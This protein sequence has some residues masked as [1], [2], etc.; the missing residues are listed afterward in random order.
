MSVMAFPL[1]VTFQ[2]DDGMRLA[3]HFDEDDIENCRAEFNEFS[4]EDVGTED[5][6]FTYPYVANVQTDIPGLQAYLREVDDWYDAFEYVLIPLSE[7]TA[8]NKDVVY[9]C[10]EAYGVEDGVKVAQQAVLVDQEELFACVQ[11]FGKRDGIRLAIN[12]DYNYLQGMT[13]YEDLGRMFVRE[14]GFPENA[15]EYGGADYDTFNYAAYAE[16]EVEDVYGGFATT[17]FVYKL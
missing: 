13:T 10:L 7:F 12:A 14:N 3:I 8:D 9:L 6:R 4:Y 11:V 2:R 17:G 1:S 5:E 15:D 16:D